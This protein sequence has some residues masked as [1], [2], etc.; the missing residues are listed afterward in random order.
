MNNQLQP[1]MYA[2]PFDSIR[3]LDSGREYWQARDLQTLLGYK[4]WREFADAIER[5]MIACS[6]SG[7]RP[8]DHFGEAHKMI[9]AGKGA[10]REVKDYHLTRY[11]CYLVAMNGDP[12]RIEISSAQIYF[13]IKTREAEL[14]GKASYV[15]HQLS[16]TMRERAL[17][18]LA[19]V[20]RGYFSLIVELFK[21][22]YNLEAVLNQT[23]DTKAMIE[24][25]VGKRWAMYARSVLKVTDDQCCTYRYPR[26]D[27]RMALARAYPVQL[28]A[29][30]D[31]WLWTVYFEEQFPF[32]YRYRAKHIGRP[33]PTNVVIPTY[34]RQLDLWLPEPV[35]GER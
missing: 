5:A 1:I 7:Q 22:L 21:H 23:L 31:T 20:P 3:K 33:A 18:L 6:N 24:T 34:V 4:H 15:L 30:F 19:Y 25:S 16:D 9:Q 26:Q 12:R 35:E 29:S 8:N 2:S 27:G 11:G 10:R 28:L 32:Y 17:T 14:T 13:A